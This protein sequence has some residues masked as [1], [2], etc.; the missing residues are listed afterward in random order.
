[1]LNFFKTLIGIDR[2]TDGP[3]KNVN[4]T[5]VVLVTFTLL[6]SNYIW[7]FIPYLRQIPHYSIFEACMKCTN[8][9]PFIF[10]AYFFWHRKHHI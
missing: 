8:T 9:A 1:M 7:I 10:L 4:M 3:K 5:W 6:R 2:C